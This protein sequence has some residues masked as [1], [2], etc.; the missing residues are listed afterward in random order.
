MKKRKMTDLK[1]L[2]K[3]AASE[4]SRS[5][6]PETE[7]YELVNH[8]FGLTKTDILLNPVRDL[9]E[10][11]LSLFDETVKKRAT[12]YPLQYILGEWD[13]YGFTFGVS[14]GVLI[15]RNETEQIAHEA[16]EFLRNKKNAVVFD[17]CT[18][19]GCIGLSV[20]ANN[21][22]CSVYMFDI[23]PYALNCSR[24][25]CRRLGLENVQILDYD[26]FSGFDIDRLPVPDVI[27]SNPPY[28]TEDEFSTLEAE[29]FFEPKEAIVAEGDGLCFYRA[30]C[31]KWL[32]YLKEGGYFMFESGEGQPDEI[33]KMINSDFEA[34]TE[35]DMYGVCRFVSGIRRS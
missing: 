21:P 7:A 2:I 11:Q 8:I 28:V 3:S 22:G 6:A 13:F 32:P 1:K 31:E 24:K 5:D 34:K 25:N 33:I 30:L 26:M 12:G 27:L 15:P 4:L 29:I 17:I 20:A 16:C 35:D 19:S 9:T 18:G 10:E 23:S 14:E